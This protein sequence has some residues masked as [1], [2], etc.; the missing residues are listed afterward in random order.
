MAWPKLV[1]TAKTDI[2]VT[3]EAEDI[4]EFGER[5]TVL[6]SDLKCNYQSVSQVK[7]TSDKEGVTITGTALFDGDICEELAEITSGKVVVFGQERVIYRGSKCR[8][9]DGTVNYT[10]LELI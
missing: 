7:Y 4:N 3:I 1:H 2:H 8:N 5:E 6:D 9:P 10:R